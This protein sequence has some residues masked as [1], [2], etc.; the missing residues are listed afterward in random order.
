M[1]ATNTRNDTTTT[2]NNNV[3]SDDSNNDDKVKSDSNK[4]EGKFAD[5][6]YLGRKE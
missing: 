1:G 5:C 2:T 4:R 3:N 6:T